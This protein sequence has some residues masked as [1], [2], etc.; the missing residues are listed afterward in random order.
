MKFF[1][2]KSS[3]I[4]TMVLTFAIFGIAAAQFEVQSESLITG[5]YMNAV[6]ANNRLYTANG[7]GFKIFDIS[8]NT[9]VLQGSLA[10][11]GVCYDC[12][13][14][15]NFLYV[16]D[17]SNGFLVAL[18]AVPTNPQIM[19]RASN[20]N[21]PA[22]AVAIGN[23]RAFVAMEGEGIALVNVSAPANPTV[24]HQLDTPGR[25]VDIAFANDYVYVSDMTSVKSYSVTGDQFTLVDT[26]TPHTG[27]FY[28]LAVVGN[29]LYVTSGTGGVEMFSLSNGQMTY[30]TST[31][32]S[33][34]VGVAQFGSNLAVSLLQNGIMVMN[35]TGAALG[36]FTGVAD[37]VVGVTT[38]GNNIYA[39]EGYSGFEVIDASVPSSMSVV[40][41]Y[42]ILGGPRAVVVRGDYA[43]IA[44][45]EGGLVVMDVTT[46]SSPQQVAQVEIAG[47]TYD[48]V[49]AGNTAFVCE[50]FSGVYA[51]DIT[52]PASPS[53]IGT[54]EI[55]ADGS[56]ALATN[57]SSYLILVHYTNGIYKL[58]IT[59][60]ASI[61]LLGVTTTDGEP[62]DVDLNV[63]INHA[64]V[65]DYD[66]GA[67]IYNVSGNTPTLVSSYATTYCRA[68]GYRD[69]TL[70]AGSQTGQM[71]I[72][73]ITTPASP[74]LIAD[75]MAVGDIN[76]IEVSPDI[77]V[78]FLCAWDRGIEAVDVATLN[79]P[80][81]ALTFDTHGLGKACF[82]THADSTLYVAD[83][84]S[85]Y[86]FSV[87][88][89]VIPRPGDGAPS[90]FELTQNFPNPF[91]PATNLIFSLEKS[92]YASLVVY[93]VTG[94]EVARLVDGFQPAGSYQAIFDASHLSSGVYYARLIANGNTQTRKMLLLK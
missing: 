42:T 37:D 20:L 24:M 60:P 33:F 80:R 15:N 18:V 48:V 21:G 6:A 13:F 68:V 69:R 32:T 12:A 36:I 82:Y 78:V 17:G 41:D 67:D 59:N 9:P 77:P 39:L 38:F 94:R 53:V 22:R 23:L 30:I 14:L 73:D 79:N 64:Y 31:V 29:T 44:D 70:F 93:D 1:Y 5:E 2:R 10:T 3:F 50:F 49:I 62:R 19:G 25:A 86:I 65:A 92:G 8:G 52:I 85:F 74:T 43:Y 35:P 4:M 57:G 40:G 56:R 89:E 90:T 26:E 88:T 71:D 46:P 81:Q 16:A 61:Q 55:T 54:Y 84:Y 72:I 75:Y 76:G 91:N 63:G 45:H 47:W 51:I 58:N 11:N 7:H 87:P 83:T 66:G 27:S 34:A 28:G